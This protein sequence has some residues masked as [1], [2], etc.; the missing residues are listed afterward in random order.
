M[1]MHM[2]WSPGRGVHH[3]PGVWMCPQPGSSLKPRLLGSFWRRDRLW[4]TRRHVSWTGVNWKCNHVYVLSHVYL[5][6]AS[7]EWKHKENQ[8]T[9][10]KFLFTLFRKYYLPHLFPSFTKLTNIYKPVLGKCRGSCGC[11]LF[12]NLD[13]F[14]SNHFFLI[15]NGNFV[16]RGLKFLK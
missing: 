16:V 3:L 6:A 2:E 12:Q 9:G 8:E 4:V 11:R 13:Y 5:K 14:L 1:Q 15:L 10:F 7:L